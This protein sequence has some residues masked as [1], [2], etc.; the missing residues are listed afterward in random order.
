VVILKI[1]KTYQKISSTRNHKLDTIMIPK[2]FF[3][4]NKT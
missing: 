4:D 3:M 1:A 2:A